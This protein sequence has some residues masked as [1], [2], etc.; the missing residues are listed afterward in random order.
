MAMGGPLRLAGPEAITA[1]LGQPHLGSAAPEGL[2]ATLRRRRTPPSQARAQAEAQ[3]TV[4][5]TAVVKPFK[6]M[7]SPIW[8]PE[9]TLPPSLQNV[10]MAFDRKLVLDR[11][12]SPSPGFKSPATKT[13]AGWPLTEGSTEIIAAWAPGAV[14]IQAKAAALASTDSATRK[15][16]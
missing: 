16:M 4:P 12:S 5:V 6:R 8:I 1:F 9:T 10:T 13:N 14:T 11:N 3:R 2:W 15:F 7:L